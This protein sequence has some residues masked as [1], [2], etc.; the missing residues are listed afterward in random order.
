MT[1]VG[2]QAAGSHEGGPPLAQ[3]VEVARVRGGVPAGNLRQRLDVR[4]PPAA[5]GMDDGIRTERR[6][7]PFAQSLAGQVGVVPQVAAGRVG[8]RDQLDREPVEQ[9][10]RAELRL[11][12]PGRDLVVDPVGRVGA[13]YQVDTEDLDELVFQ[14][15]PRRRSPVQLPV[16]A[17]GPPDGARVGLDGCAVGPRDAQGG[18]AH[19]LGHEH[20]GDVMVGYHQQVGR[21]GERLVAREKLRLDVA[22]PADQRQRGGVLVDLAGDGTLALVE[23]QRAVRME[24][25][26]SGH[27]P[28]SIEYGSS[29]C[30]RAHGFTSGLALSI[31]SPGHRD[32]GT[33]TAV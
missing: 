16:F 13:G 12:D 28:S 6:D 15:V 5:V 10:L 8:G 33:L 22:V 27:Q 2:G 21:I 23:R 31:A 17:E 1:V 14:P 24:R 32:R 26:R 9:L 20:A 4:A 25:E 19:A 3:R 7:D 11:G 30:L 29:K 18:K